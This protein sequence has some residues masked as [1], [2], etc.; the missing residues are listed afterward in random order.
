[1]QWARIARAG[2]NLLSFVVSPYPIPVSRRLTSYRSMQQ[3]KSPTGY[4]TTRTG[5]FHELLRW[6]TLR[7]RVEG[8]ILRPEKDQLELPENLS[9]PVDDPEFLNLRKSSTAVAQCFTAEYVMLRF[10]P[11]TGS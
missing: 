10:A 7:F 11:G 3:V 1:M 5:S 9:S 6:E 2:V 8:C 4:L